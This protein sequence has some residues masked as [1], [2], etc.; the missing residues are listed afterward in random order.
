MQSREDFL[1]IV[2]LLFHVT[3][4]VVFVPAEGGGIQNI[5]S[6]SKFVV[7]NYRNLTF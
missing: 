2:G 7:L 1:S 5:Q 3:C 6:R 4:Q